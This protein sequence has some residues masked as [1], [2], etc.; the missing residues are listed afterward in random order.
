MSAQR[1]A[2]IFVTCLSLLFWSPALFAGTNPTSDREGPANWREREH[3][4]RYMAEAGSEVK[5]HGNS[6]LELRHGQLLVEAARAGVVAT[7]AADIYLKRRAL[8]L[9]RVK[10]H[11]TRILVIWDNGVSAVSVVCDRHHVRLGPGD[12][13][14]LADHHPDQGEIMEEDEIGRRRIQVSNLGNG[15]TVTTAEF[16]L[17]QALEREPLLCEAFRAPDERDRAL[18]EKILKTA[19]VLNLVTARRGFY[20]ARTRF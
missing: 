18:K 16:S 4:W 5:E 2:T 9:L 15:K 1:M 7:P 13:A 14:L 19:A 6:R 10:E 8:V 20:T 3:S 11:S 12:E 17:L